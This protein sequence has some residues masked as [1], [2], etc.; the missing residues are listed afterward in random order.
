MKAMR[1]ADSGATA[2][3]VEENTAAL[4]LGSAP[5]LMLC[6]RRWSLASEGRGTRSG[7]GHRAFA[8]EC[9][10]GTFRDGRYASRVPLIYILWSGTSLLLRRSRL[11]PSTS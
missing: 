6:W 1:L 4:P 9:S 10:G 8:R 5:H 3:L 7:T 2:V 11:L